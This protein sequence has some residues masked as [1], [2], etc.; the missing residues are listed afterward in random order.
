MRARH[1]HVAANR[2]LHDTLA[3]LSSIDNRGL[4]A[5]AV[6]IDSNPPRAALKFSVHGD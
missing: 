3:S 5:L 1:Q 6:Q 4:A 2:V